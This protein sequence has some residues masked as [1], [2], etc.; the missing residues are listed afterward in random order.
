MVLFCACCSVAAWGSPLKDSKG[1]ETLHGL[2]PSSATDDFICWG[3]KSVGWHVAKADPRP[4][5]LFPLLGKGPGSCMR[6]ANP[7]PRKMRI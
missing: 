1:G 4:K 7:Q 3:H 2:C 5:E 6:S